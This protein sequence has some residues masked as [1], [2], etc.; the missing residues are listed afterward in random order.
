M[1][2]KEA[3]R[4]LPNGAIELTG[5]KAEL[6]RRTVSRSNGIPVERYPG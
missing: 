4:R 3:S 2:P 6:R 5:A 1:T